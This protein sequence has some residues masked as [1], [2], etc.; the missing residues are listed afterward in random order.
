[1]SQPY[2]PP[3]PYAP[4]GP[5]GPY[6]PAGPQGPYAPPAAPAPA[7]PT[8]VVYPGQVQLPPQ[9]QYAPTP[10]QAAVRSGAPATGFPHYVSPPPSPVNRTGLYV[11]ILVCVLTVLFAVLGFVIVG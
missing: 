10:Q 7:A 2:P 6:A 1:L 4:A 5:Q 8:Q 9:P 11:G 3:A